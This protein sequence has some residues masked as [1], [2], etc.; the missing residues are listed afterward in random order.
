MMETVVVGVTLAGSFGAAL[1]LQRAVLEIWL[2]A[3][4]PH[5]GQ[6]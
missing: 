3:I 1:L 6:E 2:R 5:R 4:K